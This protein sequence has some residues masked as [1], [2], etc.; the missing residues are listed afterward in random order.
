MRPPIFLWEPNDLLVF[1]SVEKAE[2][3]VEPPDVKA[4]IAYDAEGRLLAFEANGRRTLLR[5]RER[6]PTHGAELRSAITQASL[7]V[8]AQIDPSMP[9]PELVNAALARFRV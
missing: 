9:L 1:D 6:E 5:E 2:A 4:G 7:A 3:F 8:G